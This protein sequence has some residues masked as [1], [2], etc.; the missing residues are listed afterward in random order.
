MSAHR[1]PDDLFEYAEGAASRGLARDH[2]RRRRRRA[3]A[4]HAR[5]EDHGARARRAG[6]VEVPA[7]RGLAAVHRADA[8]SGIPVATFAIGEAGAA[9]AALFAAAMLAASDAGARAQARRVSRSAD[10]QGARDARA[11]GRVVVPGCRTAP[12]SRAMPPGSWLGLLGGGQLGRMF[13]MA[14][15]SLGY[16]VAVLDPGSDSPAGSGRRP[17]TCA[18]TTSTTTRS[19]GWRRAARR[20]H[21]VRERARRRARVPR[22][23][24]RTSRRRPRSVAIAQDRI[25]EKG[26][27]ADSG[28]A[29]VP[30]AVLRDAADARAVDAALLPGIVKTRALRLRRQGT[31]ARCAPSTRWS[32]RSPRWAAAP[33]CSSGASSLACEVSVVVARDAARTVRCWPV[34]ENRHR[35]GILDVSIAPAARRRATLAQRARDIA[36]GV[37]AALDYDGVLCVEMFVTARR[38][39]AGQRDRA[40]PAQQRPLHDRRVRDVAVRAAGA[41]AGR[42]AARRDHAAHA[43]R[44]AEPARR[45]V[46]P[47]RW[48]H[49]RP[50]PTGPRCSRTATRSS[51]CTASRRR[52]RAARWATSPASARRS[53]TRS[54]RARAIRATLGIPGATCHDRAAGRRAR[55]RPDAPPA[56]ARWRRSTSP[57]S[58]PTSSRSRTPARATTRARSTR[59]RPQPNAVFV[60]LNRGKRSVSLDLKQR[61]RPCGVPGARA[62]RRRGGRGL[63]S[64]RGEGA[65]RRPRRGRRA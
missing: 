48:R 33:A 57:T 29:V 44:D 25:R 51:T 4:R 22:A 46:V 61:R 19:R 43:G 56:R 58:A 59:R 23:T 53:T 10:G 52:G 7:R 49:S 41:R 37:A 39:A 5:R 8:A 11:A 55:A 32:T 34:A 16:R 18:P 14:A 31:G 17:A 6:A 15:Q 24:A 3:P 62:H 2:R 36:T 40:A 13:C 1:M 27:L 45:P 60:A 9:N 47:R 12:P 26:F 21:R 30:F 65:R 42:A 35:D 54:R 38:R 50:S 28:F 63:P 64:R 20:D